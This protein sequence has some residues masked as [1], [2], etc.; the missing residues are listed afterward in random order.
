MDAT[1]E[2]S[3]TAESSQA[4]VVWTKA[5]LASDCCHRVG[6]ITSVVSGVGI[7]A[8]KAH[9][10]EAVIAARCHDADVVANTAARIAPVL[11]CADEALE[12]AI[13]LTREKAGEEVVAAELRLSLD[14][15]GEIVGAI[16]TDDILDRVF[17]RFCIGK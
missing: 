9:L 4:T 17:S 16:Y 15:L 11:C 7:E 10:R 12:Q 5:D 8:L 1:S 2:C 3:P 6:I 14:A 13:D